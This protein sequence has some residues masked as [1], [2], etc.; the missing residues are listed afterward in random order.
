M[1]STIRIAS[2]AVVCQEATLTGDI[3]IGEGTIIQP[4][5]S[6]IAEAGPIIIGPNNIIEELVVIKNW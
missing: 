4:K 5:A 3:T 1:I 2:S 6:I